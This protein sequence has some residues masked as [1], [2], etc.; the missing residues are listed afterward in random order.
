[1]SKIT[2]TPI[3][4]C[5]VS[6]PLKHGAARFPIRLNYQRVYG[7]VH[8]STEVIQQLRF[9]RGELELPPEV[10]PIL[11]R[12]GV[13]LDDPVPEDRPSDMVIVEISSSRAYLLGDI[14]IQRNYLHQQF[15]DFFARPAR[16]RA[17][18]DLA[19][20]ADPAALREFLENDPVYKLYAPEGQEI[21]AGLTVRVQTFN[22]L[23]ADMQQIVD[24]VGKDRLLFVTHVN[25]TT[26]DG[27]L[28]ASRDKLIRWVKSS[29]AEL[30]VECFDPSQL[31]AEFGQ[32]RAME[33][34]GL[35]STHYT[36]AFMDAWFAKVQRDYIF[37]R[38]AGLD[39]GAEDVA[40]V[41][42]ARIAETI[43]ATLQDYDFFEGTRRLFAALQSHPDDVSLKVLHGHVLARIG[44]YQGAAGLLSSYVGA[45]EM[46]HE[47]REDLLRALME[48]G[49]PQGA[50]DLA[51]QMLG[52]E[53]ESAE[54]YEV[55]GRAAQAL[56]KSDDAV[57]Y[58]KLAFR[59]A[60]NSAAAAVFIL[61]HYK[62]TG[63]GQLYDAWLAEVLEILEDRG[64]ATLAS[65]LA[66][67][68]ISRRE[69]YAL[70]RALVVL[71][72]K[73]AGL[74]PALIEEAAR[75]EMESALPAVAVLLAGRPGIVE[76][77]VRPLR[78]MLQDWAEAAEKLLNEG[79]MQ[80]AHALATAC[81][82]VQPHQPVARA[83]SRAVLDHL[84]TQVQSASDDAA[85]VALCE[86][87]GDMVFERRSIALLFGRS[88]AK[89]GRLADAQRVAAR[90]YA[91]VPD[92]VAACANYAY[93]AA[94]NKDFPTAL[95]LYGELS[96]RDAESTARFHARI[97]GFLASA[98]PRGVRFIR[99]LTA[100]GEFAK[101]VETYR[102]LREYAELPEEQFESEAR[103]LLSAMRAHLRQIDEE[104]GGSG[105]VLEIVTLMLT[106]APTDPR[107]LRR[108][109]IESMKL[110]D[111]ERAM[112][113]WR[114][115]EEV[116]PGLQSAISNARRCE[117][118]AARKA[119]A[120]RSGAMVPLAA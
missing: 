61:D 27:S 16:A 23:R 112:G 35:D 109:G 111:F 67:W 66:E 106:L 33:D 72:S 92:D 80:E 116:S 10:V 9:R 34:G 22:E 46:T 3:G 28:I 119:R 19:R 36:N 76:K 62:S 105:E 83:V 48:T 20:K 44:D 39:V 77:L 13:K 1:M 56:G 100:Q 54:I 118:I 65:G 107:L 104:E 95:E 88:L 11:F 12:P 57:R 51:T 63:E 32:E 97:E 85:V 73:D 120:A 42:G 81:L 117:T 53:Y 47:Y 96:K 103:R 14:A 98:G 31:M 5:R 93:M 17:Y 79:R 94:L 52:D 69:E 50:F 99:T 29:A 55:A 68:A 84:S 113:F 21:L 90:L 24:M 43:A 87:A 78:S 108:A 4:T 38:A 110:E 45:P 7:F 70:G 102:L 59:R 8:T 74:L 40:A 114:R 89:L 75:A 58:R 15:S 115:L 26:P 86:A 2:I 64:D 25:V 101:A 37:P 6:T 71:G 91:L 49:D 18:Y 60:P 82:A 41:E 30:G